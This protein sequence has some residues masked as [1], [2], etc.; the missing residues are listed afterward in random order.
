MAAL[1]TFLTVEDGIVLE[2]GPNGT[3]RFARRN[4][5]RFGLNTERLIST[6][7]T[8]DDVIMGDVSR[9]ERA[10]VQLEEDYRPRVIFVV[11]SAILAVTGADI[12]G[13]CHYMSERISAKLVT[14][15]GGFVGDYS[16][17]IRGAY[18]KMVQALTTDGGVKAPNRYNILGA[19]VYS[20]TSL[21]DVSE[22]AFLME[23]AFGAK[24]GAT[25]GMSATTGDLAGMGAAALNL[26]L[27]AE[28]LPAARWLEE[29]WGTPF[30]YPPPF[31][32]LGT[33]DFLE[34]VGRVLGTGPAPR[35][36][37]A[38][39]EPPSSV[40]FPE[41]VTICG[42]YDF[43]AG[44]S[45]LTD[46][47]GIKEKTLLSLHALGGEDME[48]GDIVHP[49]TEKELISALGADTETPIIADI[50]A[51]EYL[52]AGKR[53]FFAGSSSATASAMGFRGAMKIGAYLSDL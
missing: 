30:V 5:T 8:E 46:E 37:A 42:D 14:Y 9:L 22:L 45:A 27:R 15:E 40:T 32:V 47:L 3:T 13:V 28:A 1:W 7:L 35:A 33:R 39:K 31:G 11:P 10:I 29:Q 36:L 24:C 23:E 16:A 48:A 50:L 17:G 25:L 51:S 43:V 18:T 6:G 44:I 49:A 12:T 38:G 41:R 20:T 52:P 26:V 21:Y 34:E 4:L 19:S 53:A 2:Y